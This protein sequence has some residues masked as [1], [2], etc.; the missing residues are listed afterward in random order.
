MC[1]LIVTIL[2]AF[3]G[4][5]LV[6]YWTECFLVSIWNL[7][8]GLNECQIVCDLGHFMAIYSPVYVHFC[9]KMDR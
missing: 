1:V 6:S 2:G 4:H 9:S 5:I 3:Y 8:L 7:I